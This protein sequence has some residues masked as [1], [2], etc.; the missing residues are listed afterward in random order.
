MMLCAIAVGVP[1]VLSP[2]DKLAQIKSWVAEDG[3]LGTL[4]AEWVES[5]AE[6]AHGRELAKKSFKEKHKQSKKQL[7]K[8]EKKLTASK[9]EHKKCEKS[10]KKYMKSD[11][12]EPSDPPV[13]CNIVVDEAWECNILATRYCRPPPKCQII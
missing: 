6:E 10:F 11:V 8:C 5:S 7:K 13:D 3:E 12:E 4:V 9:K 2:S 1:A